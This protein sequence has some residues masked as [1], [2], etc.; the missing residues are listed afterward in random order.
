MP[1]TTY[2]ALYT[3]CHIP[4]TVLNHILYTLYNILYTMYHILCVIDHTHHKPSTI[5]YTIPCMYY[6]FLTTYTVSSVF[7]G[8]QRQPGHRT[9]RSSR[10]PRRLGSGRPEPFSFCASGGAQRLM[11]PCMLGGTLYLA[12][13]TYI[14]KHV[15]VCICIC[16]CIC[17]SICICMCICICKSICICKC[18]IHTMY[19]I[20]CIHAHTYMY[21]YMRLMSL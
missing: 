1:Y 18:I 4:S 2:H 13:L 5:Y 20:L 21:V 9:P 10:R 6:I 16:I 17:K 8:P 3:V 7:W 14:C 12:C 15:C 19:C 11:T